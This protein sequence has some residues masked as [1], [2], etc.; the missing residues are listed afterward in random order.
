[1]IVSRRWLEA[2]LG[3]PLDAKEVADRLAML[4]A[5][6]DAVVPLHQDLGDVLIA[7]VLEVKPHPNADRL[8]LCQ[9]DAGTGTPLEV[10]CGAPNV[11]AGKAYPFAPVGATLPGGLKLD[12]RKIRGIESNGMLCSAKELGLGADHAGILE[13]DTTAAPG[14][15]FLDAIPIADDQIVLDVSANR[16]DL[17]CHKGVARELAAVMGGVVKL[18]PV[19]RAD[20]QTARA[21]APVRPSGRQAVVDGVEVRL[22]DP[23]GA[24]RYMIAVIRGVKVGPSPAW[25][26]HRL[27]SLGHRP[28]N[29]VVDATNYVLFEINQPLHAF[30]LAKLRGPA[31]VVRRAKAS[32]KIVTLD[33]VERKLT[34]E[35][36]AICDAERPTIV[37]GV[38]G[39][40]DSEVSATTTDLVLECAY[41][42]PTRIR[43][44]RR[45]LGL[46]S[47]SSY[48]FERGIDM[49]AMPDALNRAI[50]LIRAV[51]GGEVR[52]A[53]IDLW[54]EPQQPRSVFLRPE[55][56]TRL[57]GVPVPRADVERLLSAVGFVAA[58]KDER[59]AAQVPS[60]RIDVTREVD[61]IEEVARLRGYQ[62][63]PDELRP[64]RPGTVPDAPS[65]LTLGR[66][67]ERLAREGLLEARTLSLGPADDPDA[68]AVQNPLSAEEGHLRSR[69]L[70]G[71]VRR[72]EHN[73]RAGERDVRLFEAG[74]VFRKGKGALPDE[75]LWLGIVLTG[76][77]RPPHWT[78]GG[79]A[80]VPDMDIW[81]LKR[82]FE[83][84]VGVA[85]P[86]GD[87]SLTVQPAADGVGWQA[88]GA[89][90]A[91]AGW[92]GSLEADAPKWA[93]PLYG[94]EVRVTVA[95]PPLARYQPVPTQPPVSRDA[96][97]VV[98]EGITAAAM[99]AVLRKTGGALLTRL[100]VLDEYR[101]GGA[102]LP[103]GNRGVTW[104]CTF[105]DPSRTLTDKEVD[106]L[107]GRMLSALEG[108]LDVRR[109]EA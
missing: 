78:D 99:E 72:V 8:S 96:S 86:P 28:I 18:P 10:V 105:R 67:R 100:D 41:F 88:V 106:A 74:V 25:L 79:G 55:R 71:L 108:E 107:L 82:H 58:P 44:T 4:C 60:W 20:G 35:M 27:T 13:L 94:L 5:P 15:R 48:R 109:R 76:A 7:R 87:R 83:L 31:V 29:N 59:L 14:T 81:D 40:T 49:L 33:G 52:E 64:Y 39:S 2:L 30:D 51:A 47:E 17:L 32:E 103:A 75:Q 62:S 93:G 38:M 92:A 24:P 91:V 65:E 43:R 102:G 95:P 90:G 26:A 77:R 34:P 19:G 21:L 16:P 97:L 61:L 3:R 63:F 85:A 50:D 6:V 69:L 70:P 68:I 57:L 22:E 89:D 36:T 73:W 54:P 46:S 80:K 1:M 56:V 12:R 98:P 37:A 101:A 23:E 42:Q 45:A 104:R 66:I 11:Q 9:V 53:P 84:A